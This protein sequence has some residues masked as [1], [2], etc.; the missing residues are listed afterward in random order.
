MK[1]PGIKTSQYFP[2]PF[3]S[4]WENIN[5]KVDLSNYAIKTGLEN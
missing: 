5:G 2:K 4:S 1:F 3:K